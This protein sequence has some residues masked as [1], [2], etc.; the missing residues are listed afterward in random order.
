VVPLVPPSDKPYPEYAFQVV[1]AAFS[2]FGFPLPADHFEELKRCFTSE[3]GGGNSG[4]GNSG[5][6]VVNVHVTLAGSEFSKLGVSFLVRYKE[7]TWTEFQGVAERVGLPPS[8]FRAHEL[9]YSEMR[10]GCGN[11]V[12]LTVSFLKEEFSYGVYNPGWNLYL[13]WSG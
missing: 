11:L 5:T 7:T 6:G 8:Y 12:E 13:G 4:G 3:L 9:P 2:S 1:V 10:S